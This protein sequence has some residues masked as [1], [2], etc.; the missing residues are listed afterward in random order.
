MN[1]WNFKVD[2]ENVYGKD[3]ISFTFFSLL[4][5]WGEAK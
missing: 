1:Q 2:N 4:F 5:I 3:L